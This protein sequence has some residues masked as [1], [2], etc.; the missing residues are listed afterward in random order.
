[1]SYERDVFIEGESHRE[2]ARN[3]N[4]ENFFDDRVP[5][6]AM[7]EQ[8]KENT[9]FGSYQTEFTDFWRGLWDERSIIKPSP[10]DRKKIEEYLQ[11]RLRVAGT[12]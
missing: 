7:Y 2:R 1:M 5:T 12:L 9:E 6:I 11:S 8:I 4:I 3:F 10:E